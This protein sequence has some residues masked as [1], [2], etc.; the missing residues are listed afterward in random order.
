MPEVP[1]TLKPV[2][3]G[4]AVHVLVCLAYLAVNVTA[5]TLP[6]IPGMG[7]GMLWGFIFPGLGLLLAWLSLGSKRRE[8]EEWMIVAI[9]YTLFLMGCGFLTLYV[10]S[11]IWGSV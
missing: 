8:M 1:P 3:P 5:V 11:Q 7:V 2:G 6:F 4:C 10:V 9:F